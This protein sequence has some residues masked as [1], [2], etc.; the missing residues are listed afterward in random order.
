MASFVSA[1]NLQAFKTKQDAFNEGKF[2]KKGD[3]SSVYRVKGSCDFAELPKTGAQTG[4]VWNVTDRH[5]M[6]Y[7]WDGEAWDELGNMTVAEWASLEGKPDFASLYA[8]KTHT[9]A[10]DQVTG[11]PTALKNPSALTVQLNGANPTTYDGSAAKT[12][13]VTPAAIGAAPTSHTHAAMGAA[14]ASAAGAAG[15]VPAPAAGDQGKFLKGDGTWGT[16]ANTTYSNMTGATSSAAGTAGLVPAPAAGKNDQFLR[17]DGSWA[18][19]PNTTYSP[20]TSSANG[21][22]S[23]S[24]KAKLDGISAGATAVTAMTDAEVNALFA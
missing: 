1:S 8:A 20:A 2:A 17:G 9:H 21:L 10:A 4:D 22:M 16:P 6:N 15:F 18:V 24:D 11:L 23:A 13:N 3:I 5:G 12:V 19:P 7:V 14:S